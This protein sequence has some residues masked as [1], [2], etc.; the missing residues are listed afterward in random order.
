MPLLDHNERPIS[1]RATTAL[2]NLIKKSDKVAFVTIK[3]LDENES[4]QYIGKVI[5]ALYN[6]IVIDV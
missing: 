1:N 3:W 5:D 6:S 2:S 4:Y